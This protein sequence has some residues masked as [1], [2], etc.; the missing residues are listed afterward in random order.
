VRARARVLSSILLADSLTA[1]EATMS[2][3]FEDEE[4]ED[5]VRT[6]NVQ[7]CLTARNRIGCGS[8]PVPLWLALHLCSRHS[9]A[10]AQAFGD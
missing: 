2:L 9:A 3:E 7:V 4:T 8:Q 1:D 10:H 5:T 6:A